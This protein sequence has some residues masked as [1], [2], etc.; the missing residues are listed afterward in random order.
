[1]WFIDNELHHPIFGLNNAIWIERIRRSYWT[2]LS[3]FIAVARLDRFSGHCHHGVVV[4][5]QFFR[6]LGRI[7]LL[8][9]RWSPPALCM[10][11]NSYSRAWSQ[12][13]RELSSDTLKW[14]RN[15]SCPRILMVDNYCGNAIYLTIPNQ[16]RPHPMKDEAFRFWLEWAAQLSALD[17]H[18]ISGQSPTA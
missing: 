17:I 6:R 14:H 16:K 4:A 15:A 7:D 11:H 9:M 12:G 1:M 8:K 5:I 18:I 10:I 13:N 2:G 3:W